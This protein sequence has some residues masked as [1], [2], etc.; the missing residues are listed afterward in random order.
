M[1]SI[2]LNHI[3]QALTPP[4]NMHQQITV[5][6]FWVAIILL[7]TWPFP[8]AAEVNVEINDD[9]TN[10]IHTTGK[11]FTIQL[12]IDYTG[13]DIVLFHWQN[14]RGDNLTEPK[15]INTGELITISAPNG[16]TGYL[17][18]VLKPATTSVALPNRQPGETREYGFAVLP[19]QFLSNSKINTQSRFGIV[20]AKLND[21]YLS[22]WIKTMTWMTASPKW[23]RFEMEKRREL[24][25][26]E[27]PILVDGEWNSDD[28]HPIS[29]EQLERLTARSKQYFEADQQTKYWET[30]IE[31]NLGGR[32]D[33]PYYWANLAAKAQVVREAAN[34]VNPDV[35]LIYQVAELRLGDVEA[36]LKS[37]AARQYDIL[38][39]HPYAWPD[40]PAPEEWLNKFINDVKKIMKTKGLDMPIWFTEVGV[41]QHGNYPG[42]FF[43]YPAT[44]AQ[45][46]GRTPYGVAIYMLKLHVMA[47][48]LG[49]EK[50]FWYNYLDRRA[51]REHAENHFGLWD[52]WGYPKPAYVAHINL[53]KNLNTKK[54]GIARHLDGNIRVY[55]FTDDEETVTV[56]WAYPDGKRNIPLSILVPDSNQEDLIRVTDPMGTAIPYD[57]SSIRITQEPIY[58]ITKSNKQ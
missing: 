48:H 50:I 30:G 4:L 32:Y 13:Q 46:Q 43:G 51:G 45:V 8:V 42:A 56:A 9:A 15:A 27:L 12:K 2:N 10:H 47:Y 21:P 5:V 52:Y 33:K 39:L 38:S 34:R 23:W 1:T 19:S 6:A 35:K 24:G 14:F 54:T 20:H 53:Q 26:L 31:E 55:D 7:L 41:P 58:I 17:G 18:L 44:G 29:R 36:F 16:H 25:L 37:D 3:A 49:V 57:G 40:F 28:T 11:P 22:G